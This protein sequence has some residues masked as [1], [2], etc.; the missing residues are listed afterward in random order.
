MCQSRRRIFFRRCLT[1][2]TNNF[3]C[4]SDIEMQRSGSIFSSWTPEKNHPVTSQLTTAR[5][6]GGGQRISLTS[7]QKLSSFCKPCTTCRVSY[8]TW[9]PRHIAL[10]FSITT[11]QPQRHS[12]CFLA[13]RGELRANSIRSLPEHSP[14]TRAKT[15]KESALRVG[16]QRHRVGQCVQV[17]RQGNGSCTLTRFLCASLP[18]R[19]S[20]RDWR[21]EEALAGLS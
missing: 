13:S 8:I 20:F 12:Q 11:S 1:G 3:S 15:K 17:V 21:A 7:P 14:S 5:N 18:V 4:K 16:L 19:A 10:H 9:R 2:R 6:L